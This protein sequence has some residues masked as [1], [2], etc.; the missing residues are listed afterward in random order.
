MQEVKSSTVCQL[1]ILGAF[2][3][4]VALRRRPC[5]KLRRKHWSQT[6][7]TGAVACTACRMTTCVSG[8]QLVLPG[9]TFRLF[10]PKPFDRTPFL[11][12][13]LLTTSVAFI[14]V[15]HLLIPTTLDNS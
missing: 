7:R 6:P 10:F 13:L 12:A 11:R 1:H 14:T 2:T 9:N 3:D 8:F 15:S 5:L 4:P